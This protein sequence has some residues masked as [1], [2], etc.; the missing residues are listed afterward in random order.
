[1][2]LGY[3][4]SRGLHLVRQYDANFSPA[5][6]GAI[7]AKRPFKTLSIPGTGITTPLGAVYSHRFDGNSVYHGMIAKVEKRFS[8]G[9]TILGSYTWSK[10]IG[11]TCGTA[12]QGN[13]T[14]CGFQNLLN[15]RSERSVDNQD[16]PHRFVT[17]ALYEL[18]IGKGRTWLARSNRAVDAV[19]GGWSLG[20]IVS[21]V[22]S[23]PFSPTVQG[24]PANTGTYTVVQRPDVVGAAYSGTRT[25]ARDFNTDAFVRPANFTYGSAG[26]NVLRGRSQFNW[27]FSA[28]K[29]FQVV[30]R[31][32]LQF[33]FEAFT[34]TNTP[35]FGAPGNVVG[36]AAFGVI[37]GANTPRNLQFGLKLLW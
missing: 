12:V 6:A 30:E 2:E 10:T 32:K 15:L 23:V 35:R 24:N 8:K 29:T 11:D 3:A 7:D 36:T 22:S 20:S 18:P 19:F 1:M 34:F 28:L 17:S 21:A 31:I 37:T 27:D 13:S 26:R 4:G 25:L 9:V 5:G 16:V 14:G 33:R